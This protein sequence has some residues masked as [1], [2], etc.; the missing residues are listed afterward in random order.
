MI[1]GHPHKGAGMFEVACGLV[2]KRLSR[3]VQSTIVSLSGFPAPRAAKYLKP[4]VF[5]FHPQY[6]VIQY[7]SGLLTCSVQFELEA[8]RPI[9]APNSVPMTNPNPVPLW[10]SLHLL[11]NR[12]PRS[13][14]FAGR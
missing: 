12:L 10:G 2:E 14:I 3:P 11:L 5:N 13:A 4:K 9:I 1:T 8:T 7:S 6:I